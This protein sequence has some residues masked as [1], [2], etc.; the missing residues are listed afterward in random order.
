MTQRQFCTFY[1]GTEL[2]GIDVAQ[3][4]EVMRQPVLSPVPLAP[5]FVSGL[6]NLRGSIVTCIDLRLRFGMKRAPV[7]IQ[8]I[9]IVIKTENGLVSFQVDR[10]ADVVQIADEDI[11]PPPANLKGDARKLVGGVHRLNN[12]LLLTLNVNALLEFEETFN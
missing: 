3:V 12:S 2:F 10:S 11:E 6:M 7:E 8:P 5:D 4:Q 9:Q 1:L